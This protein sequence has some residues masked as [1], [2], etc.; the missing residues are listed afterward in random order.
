MSESITLT[1]PNN[2]ANNSLTAKQKLD[3]WL[4]Y[5]ETQQPVRKKHTLKPVKKCLAK[6]KLKQSSSYKVITIVGTNGKG[7]C[8]H[9]LESI[10]IQTNLQVA[11]FT[12][13]H[14]FDYCER[15]RIQ[16]EN[17]SAETIVNAFDEIYNNCEHGELTYFEYTTIAAWIIFNK[18]HRHSNLDWI[19][20]EAG[21]GGRLDTVNCFDADY[22]II[23][24]IGLDHQNILGKSLENIALEKCGVF[25]TGQ[26]V[27]IAPK[28]DE[29][30]NGI[31]KQQAKNHGAVIWEQHQTINRCSNNYKISSR[32]VNKYIKTKNQR[33]NPD[34][35]IACISLA[36]LTPKATKI[37]KRQIESA[38]KH[39]NI[40]GRCQTITYKNK[41]IIADV[42][43]NPQGAANLSNFITKINKQNKKT[44]VLY[45]GL[46]RDKDNI[47]II[48]NLNKVADKLILIKSNQPRSATTSQLNKL[49]KI[50]KGSIII[51]EQKFIE[52]LHKPQKNNSVRHIVC[53]SFYMAT[54][55]IKICK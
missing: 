47:E 36:Y 52:S 34:L 54:K 31:I 18:K 12:S 45:L 42:S 40:P 23:S 5:I 32:D 35:I 1:Q 25:R 21:I 24:S 10:A 19:I 33:I 8:A 38:I 14:L 4:K 53:G 26:N 6:L 48:K 51:S 50:F 49:A 15:I 28:L 39:T 20:L 13:P 55:T 29:K 27:I 43:H 22:S 37:T 9:I 44:N 7:T 16:G 41:E 46:L 3:L 30:I 11:C 17:I 2:Y